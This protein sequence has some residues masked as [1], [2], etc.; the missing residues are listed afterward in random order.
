MTTT[1]TRRYH[2]PASHRLHLADRSEA[3]NYALFGKCNNPFGHGHNYVLS[4]TVGGEIDRLTG[5][6]LP[7]SA[8]DTYVRE[9]VLQLFA[10]RNL[11]LDILQFQTL[12]PTTENMAMVITHL[13]AE[14]WELAWGNA[15]CRLHAVHIQ[16]TDRNSFELILGS[17]DQADSLQVRPESVLVHA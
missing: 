17:I 1:L 12:I 15:R 5:L 2:F 9:K 3:D 13:L 6:I 14:H 8:L 7:V 16:E 10:Y 4:V 11:N